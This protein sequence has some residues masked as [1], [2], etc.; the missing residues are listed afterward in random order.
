MASGDIVL[1]TTAGLNL[2]ANY[3]A[4][5][6]I[7]GGPLVVRFVPA[8]VGGAQ[9]ISSDSTPAN[10]LAYAGE[11][12]GE[13]GIIILVNDGDGELPVAMFDHTKQYDITI[14]EH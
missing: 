6:D 5:D 11:Q 1:K 14:T 2:T 9:S 12:F 4:Q 13:T 8:V 3:L 7:S 10:V